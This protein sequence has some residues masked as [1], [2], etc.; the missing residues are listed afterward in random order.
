MGEQEQT[1]RWIG[2]RPLRPDG[3]DKVTGRARFGADYSLPGML[4]GKI[5]RSPHAHARILSIDTSAAKALPGVKA[6]ITG[7]DWP[8]IPSEEA[9]AGETPINLRSLSH[10]LM[11]RDK[12]L[13]DGHAVAAVAATSALI[14]EQALALIKV[15][16][17]VLPHV[18]DVRA[19]IKP[20]APLLHDDLYTEGV[21]PQPQQPSNI[22]KR[23]EFSLGDLDAGFAAADVIIERE[24]TTQ[25]VH[26]GYI[27][28]HA[29]V[30]TVSEDGQAEVWCSSQGHFTM[31]T[32][33]C[34]LLRLEQSK[35][36][37]IPAEIGGGFG[38]KTLVY[39]EP[40][41]LLLARQSGRPV[42]LAMSR[43]EV[44]RATGPAPGSYSRI[45]IGAN[46]DGKITAASA[47]V[48]LQAGAFPGAQ[49]GPACMAAFAPYDLANVSAVGYDVV[50]NR[51]KVAAYRAPGAPLSEYPVESVI[52]DLAKQLDIDPLQFRLQNAAHEGTQTAYG[53]RFK[54]IGYAETVQAALQ[55]PHYTAPLTNSSNGSDPSSNDGRVRG[56]GVASG[57]WFNIGGD[58]TAAIN[59]NED[60]TIALTT[61][62]PNIGGSRA[63]HAMMVAEE[64]GIDVA[65]VRPLIGDTSS[66]G[67][68]FLTG[69]SR[70]TFATGMAAIEASRKAI[71]ELCKR[72][73]LIWEIDPEAVSWK[74]GKA[75]PA[76]PNAGDFE[77]L[78]IGDI[79]A[80]AGKTGGPIAGYATLNAQGAGPGFG[81]H[82]CDLEVDTETG[83]VTI[84]RYTAVQDVGRAI[85]PSY[86]EGQLQGGVAQGIGW[87]LNEEYIYNAEGR[88]ENP[89]FLDYRM[90]VCSDLPM[91]DTVLVEVPNPNHPYGVRGVGEV[92]IIPPLAAVAN[93]IEN[94]LGQRITDLPLSPPRL[95]AAIDKAAAPTRGNQA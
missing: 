59:I 51:P 23:V 16:Y 17:E 55:H 94:A 2:K 9:A 60:G 75:F 88:L 24:F 64:F 63:G 21:E 47:E 6:V 8:D 81:T 48:Y 49:V 83:R 10:N 52:D 3:V 82:I 72:A 41:A 30:A 22:A 12:V 70:V 40:V 32:Y 19:A 68:T 65:Q 13:Y 33:L 84:L 67:Y 46:R 58:S 26:Q 74:D 53:P 57:F 27:E 44:F 14:A 77:P 37:V 78:T 93:A 29:T 79:A 87:A 28:P 15:E 36:R 34:K 85:H 54:V 50:V 69:G 39:L 35:V 45:K 95:L 91:I 5:L 7:A 25:P 66:I 80:K 31:R 90:P 1:F 56:R 73:A 62:S 89:G 92:P 18:I 11:A 71:Q 20:D 42:K 61:G 38:G 76:G 86:V 43:E 4:S